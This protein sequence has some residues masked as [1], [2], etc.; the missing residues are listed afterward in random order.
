MYL[1]IKIVNL[2]A[3]KIGC[4]WHFPKNFLAIIIVVSICKAIF[5]FVIQPMV[6]PLFTCVFR[7]GKNTSQV[8]LK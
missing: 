1:F 5:I 2:L 3:F 8:S 7:L 6:P 4:N